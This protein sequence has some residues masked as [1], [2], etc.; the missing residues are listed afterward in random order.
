MTS[1]PDLSLAPGCFGWAL[2][3]NPETN[4]C[5]ACPFASSCEPA[6]NL[7]HAKLCA[8]LGVK[9]LVKLPPARAR[10]Q[11]EIAAEGLTTALPLK[12]QALVATIERRGLK[13]G[14]SLRAGKNPFASP[15]FLRVASHLLL[16]LPGGIDRRTLSMALQ[17][18]LEWGEATANAH[19][20]QVF[21]LLPALGAATVM[22]GKL[23]ISQ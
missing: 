1:R 7:A 3:F 8:D 18:K 10:R 15:A 9:G 6:A 17:H 23:R 22:N 4:E 21:S 11:A 16:K 12:V 13:V 20:S 19:A 5:K 14:E 2:A